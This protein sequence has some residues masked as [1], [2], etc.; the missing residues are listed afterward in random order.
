MKPKNEIAEESL[1]PDTWEGM[2]LQ[3]FSFAIRSIAETL[4]FSFFKNL[5]EVGESILAKDTYSRATE[6][7]LIVLWLRTRKGKKE[8]FRAARNPDKGL[9]QIYEW[10]ES[11]GI[12]YG[13]PQHDSMIQIIFGDLIKIAT[14]QLGKVKPKKGQ[15]TE[16][17]PQES[18]TQPEAGGTGGEEEPGKHRGPPLA[19]LPSMLEAS[20]E[21]SPE[22]QNLGSSGDSPSPE[23]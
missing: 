7:A 5:P 22:L 13:T 1:I 17:E 3:P 2:E 10:A 14:A 11:K 23:E 12:D 20:Q 4:G 8:M 15:K 6:D 21:S 9:I 18:E 19:S 16:T